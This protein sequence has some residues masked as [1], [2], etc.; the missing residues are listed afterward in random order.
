[1]AVPVIG[2]TGGIGSGKSTVTGILAQL[3]ARGVDADRIGRAGYP[4]GTGG[5]A[6]AARD[7]DRPR[8]GG[9]RAVARG[10]RAADGCT[11]HRRGPPPR[12]PPGDRERRHARRAAP[13]RGGGVAHPRTVRSGIVLAAALAARAAWSASPCEEDRAQTGLALAAREGGLEI[14]AVDPSS[15]AAESGLRAG[16]ALVQVNATMPRSCTDYARAIRD[17]REGRKALLV[18]VRRSE[19]TVPLALGPATWERAVATAPPPPLEAPSVRA[20]VATPAPV[21][22]PPEA[23]VSL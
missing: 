14:A 21:P 13:A 11:G 4:P 2:L 23:R 15:A 20:L 18:L 5:P 22:V 17:A 12:G 9:A 1:M 7:R 3:G 6:R 16:D 19:G 10:S 8:G